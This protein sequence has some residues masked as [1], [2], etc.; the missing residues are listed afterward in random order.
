MSGFNQIV[1]AG[2]PSTHLFPKLILNES[3]VIQNHENAKIIY[4]LNHRPLFFD[5]FKCCLIKPSVLPTVPK[6]VKHCWRNQVG[7]RSYLSTI[8]T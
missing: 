2:I 8:P 7:V 4:I 3:K 5:K 6:I 1:L